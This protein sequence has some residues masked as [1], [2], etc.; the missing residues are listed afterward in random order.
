M[1]N[2]LVTT[3]TGKQIIV[4]SNRTITHLRYDT[5]RNGT[6]NLALSV[7]P[8]SYKEKVKLSRELGQNI[9]PVI[10]RNEN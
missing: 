10:S 9:V 5:F 4:K 6:T 7:E 2:Y 8:I 3:R 1:Q